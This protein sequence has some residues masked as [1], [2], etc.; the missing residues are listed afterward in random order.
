MFD[1]NGDGTISIK[2]LTSVMR[3]LGLNPT[4]QDIIGIMNEFDIDG[5]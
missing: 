4:E 2:E 3:S 1:K 5:W